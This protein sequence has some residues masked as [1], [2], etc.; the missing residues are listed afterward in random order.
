ML[1]DN[2]NKIVWVGVTVGVVVSLGFGAYVLFPESFDI[3]GS[4]IRN[5]F[6]SR[7]SKTELSANQKNAYAL[8]K[9]SYFET[10]N[11]NQI[12]V[13]SAPSGSKYVV[14]E[15]QGY[16]ML[17]TA[18]AGDKSD[19]EGLYK[20]YMA[21]RYDN[22]ELMSWRQDI[23]AGKNYDNNATDGDL[24]IAQS[25]YKAYDRWGD[26][27]YLNQANKIADN[28]LMYNY[29]KE[30]KFLTFGN[31]VSESSQ[32]YHQ[33]RASDV[34]PTFYENF[35][36]HNND[37]RWHDLAESSLMIMKKASDETTTGLIPDIIEYRFG[38][39][40]LLT[41]VSINGGGKNVYSYDALR[42]PFN[43]A[44]S[45]D[46]RA[47]AVNHKLLTFFNAQKTIKAGYNP[48]DGS[49]TGD[50]VDDAFLIPI[51]YANQRFG[52]EFENVS[53]QTNSV[54]KKDEISNSYYT[55]SQFV[56]AQLG[57]KLN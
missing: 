40:S 7:D 31:W 34:I 49:V 15:G 14:S 30:D 23:S 4:T 25:L 33:L 38:K 43:M 8:Y 46:V 28:I 18:V 19:F 12:Y 9:K 21:N 26:K 50:Y 39:V 6:S 41:E 44:L 36:N 42:I 48:S 1:G 29:N 37:V 53:T 16:G 27:E 5:L 54:L 56:L 24:Y 20:Y 51:G 47:V 57:D 22:M 35:Y 11:G 10:I 17:M 3:M 45:D 32:E 2:T 55:D 13:N 52:D